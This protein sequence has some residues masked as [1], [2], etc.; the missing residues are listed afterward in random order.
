MDLLDVLRREMR[1]PTPL[2]EAG[3]HA[4]VAVSGGP[5]SLA[6]LHALHGL[7]TDLGLRGLSAAHFNHG[8]RGREADSDAAFVARF[9]VA[10]SIPCFVEKAGIAAEA[11]RAHVS[12]QQ[13]ARTARYAFLA[14]AAHQCG[15]D[16]VATGHTQDD[17]VETVLLHLLRGTGLDGLRG[18]PLRR[19]IYVRPLLSVSR[20]QVEAYCAAHALHPRQDSSN[21][22]TSHYTRNRIRH[23][24]LPL[25]EQGYYPGTRTS[26][27]RLSQ[28]AGADAD[29][30]QAHA[31]MVLGQVTLSEHGSPTSLTLSRMGLRAL[32]PA[33]LRHVLRAAMGRARGTT[34][35]ITHQHWAR[36]CAAVLSPDETRWELTTP[37]PHCR[38]AVQAGALTITRQDDQAA[39]AANSC[40]IRLEAGRRRELPGS[41]RHVQAELS[42]MLPLPL[43]G[44]ERAVFDARQVHLPSLHVRFWQHGD[45]IAPRG[46][47]GHTKKVQDIFTDAKVPRAQRSQVPLVAD[48][49][50]LLWVAGLTAAERGRI[51]QATRQCLVLTAS[52]VRE[53]D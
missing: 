46:M 22:D 16:K 14:R 24:L 20:A 28:I 17:Q 18:I 26:L 13:A 35:G 43:P 50:G 7:R 27:L 21:Q 5:D 47:A 12:V 11:A 23:E 31:R 25:L 38:I 37:T 3:D 4:L 6:L 49:E 10:R 40:S 51:T 29:F 34:E 45:R 30:L 41:G 36:I 2:L 52:F 42:A 33:L 39:P 9:C 44:S 15:A 8:L 32:H 48:R 19:G 1:A 53:L